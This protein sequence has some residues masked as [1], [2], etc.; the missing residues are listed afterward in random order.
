M[1]I[2]P[3]PH[4]CTYIKRNLLLWKFLEEFKRSETL[5]PLTLAIKTPGTG[6]KH[7]WLALSDT[8]SRRP[9]TH[10]HYILSL[11]WFVWWG[12][13]ILSCKLLVVVRSSSWV[14]I[15]TL[16]IFNFMENP[17][18]PYIDIGWGLQI[19]MLLYLGP[20]KY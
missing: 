17:A 13:K 2:I 14:V 18:R 15:F 12:T 6:M 4:T 16:V 7:L 10:T 3:S 11:A 8:F 5:I 1:I 9:Q 19:E 20:N